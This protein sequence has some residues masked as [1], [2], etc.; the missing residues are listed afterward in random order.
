MR[1]NLAP[2]SDRDSIRDRLHVGPHEALGMVS[3]VAV[4]RH[5]HSHCARTSGGIVA[6]AKPRGIGA[7]TYQGGGWCDAAA[8]ISWSRPM[9]PAGPGK[10]PMGLALDV[11]VEMEVQ[12]EAAV[13]PLHDLRSEHSRDPPD[14]CLVYGSNLVT[15]GG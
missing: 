1:R 5:G 14:P 2:A 8:G 3:P 7:T 13:D 11:T 10:P 6:A 4:T 9:G 12:D 15:E